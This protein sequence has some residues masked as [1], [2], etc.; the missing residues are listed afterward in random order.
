VRNHYRLDASEPANPAHKVG[1]VGVRNK[2]TAACTWMPQ[3]T[4]TE[5]PLKFERWRWFT[6]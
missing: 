2:A 1:N 3:A 5:N 4:F 6:Q